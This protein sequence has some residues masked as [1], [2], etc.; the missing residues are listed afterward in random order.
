VDRYYDLSVEIAIFV[1]GEDSSRPWAF[2]R[3][4]VVPRVGEVIMLYYP[5]EELMRGAEVLQVSY[6]QNGEEYSRCK[7]HIDTRWKKYD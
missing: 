2:R 4:P 6:T 3:W 1:E 7:V 5:K